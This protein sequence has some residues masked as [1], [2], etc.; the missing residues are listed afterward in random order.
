MPLVQESL[1]LRVSCKSTGIKC[2]IEIISVGGQSP[3]R[4]CLM[5]MQQKQQTL[6]RKDRKVS[7]GMLLQS[8][9]SCGPKLQGSPVN[10]DMEESPKASSPLSLA[11]IPGYPALNGCF[12]AD[13]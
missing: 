3:A 11:A 5:E 9:A 13:S 6:E 1:S 12:R 8:V 7:N 4:K 10:P 2:E